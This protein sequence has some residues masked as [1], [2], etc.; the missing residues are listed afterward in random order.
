[1]PSALSMSTA[2]RSHRADQSPSYLDRLA[3]A[4][5][6]GHRR[7]SDPRIAPPLLPLSTLSSP[8]P[9][10]LK[11][12]PPVSRRRRRYLNGFRGSQG[13]VLPH[14]IRGMNQNSNQVHFTPVHPILNSHS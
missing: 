10:H 12:N 9:P 3:V 7:G 11:N 5:L 4:V 6:T 14:C 8:P 1:M 2:W 13:G